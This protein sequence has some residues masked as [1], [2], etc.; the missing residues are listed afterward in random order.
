MSLDGW[1]QTLLRRS[2]PAVWKRT[3][4]KG[5]ED[6]LHIQSVELLVQR[7]D[8]GRAP[9][10]QENTILLAGLPV[11]D[12]REPLNIRDRL[13]RAHPIRPKPSVERPVVLQV[14]VSV[15]CFQPSMEQLKRSVSRCGQL[16]RCI[17]IPF[18]SESRRFLGNDTA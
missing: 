5:G 13:V 12:S 8:H 4:M 10:L 17:A 11:S 9:R 15:D 2:D 7:C 1:V 6:V 16:G 18:S 14:L 3:S